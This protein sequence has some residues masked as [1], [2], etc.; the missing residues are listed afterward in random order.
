MEAFGNVDVTGLIPQLRAPTLVIQRRGI[1][2]LPVSIGRGIASQIQN[3]RLVLLDGEAMAPYLGETETAIKAI[4]AFLDAEDFPS[5]Q[6]EPRV[7]GIS[8]IK[9]QAELEQ[10]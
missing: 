7:P 5:V 2:W 9:L 1:Q 8:S 3:A 10:P 6:G 4:E